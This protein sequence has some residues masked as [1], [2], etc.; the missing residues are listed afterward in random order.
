MSLSCPVCSFTNDD[1]GVLSRHTEAHFVEDVVVTERDDQVRQCPI[2]SYS[3]DDIGLLVAHTDQHFESGPVAEVQSSSAQ[4]GDDDEENEKCDICGVRLRLDVLQDHV[5]AHSFNNHDNQK[6]DLLDMHGMK[7]KIGYRTKWVK[8]WENDVSKDRIS[9]FQY[10]ERLRRLDIQLSTG[11]EGP[12]QRNSELYSKFSQYRTL[13]SDVKLCARLQHFRGCPGCQGFGCG[14]RNAQMMLSSLLNIDQYRT[15]LHNLGITDVPHIPALQKR[16]EGAWGEGYDPEGAAHY[17][18]TLYNT[19]CW[20]GTTEVATLFKFLGFKVVQVT[21]PKYSGANKTHP[22]MFKL[23]QNYYDRPGQPPVYLQH[24]G[25]SRTVVG[26]DREELLLFDPGFRQPWTVSEGGV[27]CTRLRK[28]LKW[29]SHLQYEAVF[30]TR[31]T[32]LV[33]QGQDKLPSAVDGNDPDN[34]LAVLRES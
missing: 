32:R 20:I 14:F 30:I 3:C 19:S 4:V 28:G 31:L 34:V 13:T 12:H 1:V 11:Y 5:I 21:F 26:V 29:M 7:K 2:C 8:C 33:E 16:I 6:M 9:S 24:L 10:H 18:G 15:H 23:L 17:S 25:H 27:G 22:A